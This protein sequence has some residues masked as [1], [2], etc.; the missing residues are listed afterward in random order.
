MITMPESFDGMLA[1]LAE[2]AAAL[3]PLPDVATVR[4]RAQERNVH[5]RMAV[6]ALALVLLGTCGGTLVAV[7]GQFRPRA[8][9]SA[10]APG[11]TAKVSSSAI[12]P[13]PAVEDASPTP[14]A[15]ALAAANPYSAV[16]GIW[17]PIKDG[18]YLVVFPDGEIGMGEAGAWQLCD[19][20]LAVGEFGGFDVDELACG[21]YGTTGLTLQTTKQ[22]KEL[23]LGVPAR[24]GAAAYTVSYQRMGAGPAMAADQ[25]LL[26][27]LV[28]DWSSLSK[29]KRSVMVGGDGAVSL[30]G[31]SSSGGAVES[32]GTI[33]GYFTDGV[34]VEIPCG[35][36]PGAQPTGAECGVVEL[37]QVGVKQIAVVG[38]YGS[39]AF[40]LTGKTSFVAGAQGATPSATQ[41]SGASSEYL[42][43][44][45]TTVLP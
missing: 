30:V 15:A 26:A 11:G 2:A 27:E 21:D 14:D 38:S 9:V 42:L 37:Q 3:T 36:K 1:E 32:A 16:A 4:R 8:E 5:R 39:E 40:V 6:S 34:R 45:A 20:R 19:G 41:D 31:L 10:V 29:D 17:Q 18:R 24:S 7:S 13:D 23:S 25:A 33:T 44:G 22:G 35:V 43:P 12:P 28:G